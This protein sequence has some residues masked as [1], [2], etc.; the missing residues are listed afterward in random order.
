MRIPEIE[1]RPDGEIMPSSE[2]TKSS[3]GNGA[4]EASGRVEA[5]TVVTPPAGNA[6]PAP[7]APAAGGPAPGREFLLCEQCQAP[8][9]R[10]QRYCVRCGARQSHARNPATSYFAAAARNRRTGAPQQRSEGFLRG[11][12]FALFL[13]LLPLGVGIGVL[14]GR[15]GSSNNNDKLI[16][17]LQKQQPVVAGAPT[18]V[19]PTTAASGRPPSGNLV[20]D[21]TLRRGFAI[22]LSTLPIQGTDQ[23][24]VTRAEQEARAKGASQVGLINPKDF[25]LTPAQSPSSYVI[26]SGQFETRA[27]AVKALAKLKSHFPGAEVIAVAPVAPAAAAPVLAHTAYGT[28]HKI[29][30]SRPTAQQVQQDKQVVQKINHTVG[31]SYVQ[32]QRGLPDTIVVTGGGGGSSTPGQSAAEKVGEP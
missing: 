8:V 21:F 25:K 14:V 4:P 26:F 2:E 5:P 19:A 29:A 11:P 3:A 28:V 23:A 30:G 24:A 15:S 31:K 6:V 18:T 12:A 7:D 27:E 10:D 17:A 32:A 9:D 22:K 16:A 13:V 20:S 1:T